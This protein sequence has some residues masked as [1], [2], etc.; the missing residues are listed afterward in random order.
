[1][2]RGRCRVDRRAPAA[3]TEGAQLVTGGAR[4]DLGGD[5]FAAL[6]EHE[7]RERE[8]VEEARALLTDVQRGNAGHQ[9][10]AAESGHRP[11]A[12]RINAHGNRAAGGNHDDGWFTLGWLAHA[13]L[14]AP[15]CASR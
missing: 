5:L 7:R 12:D 15:L 2:P 14:C 9:V 11:A 3:S 13:S 8:A 4:A 1:M 6:A 10:S